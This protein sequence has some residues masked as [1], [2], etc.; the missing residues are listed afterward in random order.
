MSGGRRLLLLNPPGGKPYARDYG[1]GDSGEEGV[2]LPPL[3]LAQLSGELSGDI[4]LLDALAEGLDVGEALRRAA[5]AAADAVIFMTSGASYLEDMPFLAALRERLPRARFIGIGDIYKDVRELAFG[6][7]P[8]LD[9][10]VLDF[11]GGQLA[12][13]L[14]GAK[15][16]PL[17]GLIYRDGEALVSAPRRRPLGPWKVRPPRWELFP[18]DKYTLPFI[19]GPAASLLTDLGCPFLCSYCPHGGGGYRARPVEDVLADAAALRRAGAAAVIIRDQSFACDRPRTM[20]LLEGLAAMGPGFSWLASTRADLVDAELLRAMKKAGCAA[21]Q[22]GLDSLDDEV[23]RSSKKNTTAARS[24]EAVRL[25]RAA[26]LKTWVT[27]LLGLSFDTRQS[28]EGTLRRARDL[29][30]DRISYRLDMNRGSVDYRRELLVRGLVP[31]ES[32]PPDTPTTTS[33]WQGRLGLSNADV[34][35][36]RRK[37]LAGRAVSEGRRR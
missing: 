26:G 16:G 5:Q 7:Q 10:A 31:P 30:A 13:Y 19:P 28:L 2:L 17:P 14:G 35:E 23:L 24:E 9:A 1:L 3:E 37:A 34:H 4:C 25:A 12:A 27:I 21:V 33:V 32:M 6:L 22:F 36:Y 11:S 8:F 20:R 18:L 15:P 29:K